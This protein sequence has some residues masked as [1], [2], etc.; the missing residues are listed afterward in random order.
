MTRRQHRKTTAVTQLPQTLSIDA[1]S[2]STIRLAGEL[3]AA[4]VPQLRAALAQTLTQRPARLILDLTDLDFCDSTGLALLVQTR[5]NLPDTS[6]LILHG[7][8]DRMHRLL[9]ITRL[10]TIFTLT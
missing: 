3:D 5:N 10:D 6:Q 4:T 1:A 8:T 9:C 2:D 7:A